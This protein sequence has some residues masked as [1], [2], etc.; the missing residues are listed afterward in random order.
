MTVNP[1]APPRSVLFLVHA[2]PFTPDPR[3]TESHVLDLVGALALPRAVVAYP[4]GTMLEAAEIRDGRVSE[5]A[6]YS[7]PLRRPAERFCV[8]HGEIEGIVRDW[9][10]LFQIA[11]VHIHH[12]MRWP[13]SLG[14]VFASAGVPYI[15]TAHDYYAACLNWNL[16]DY[17]RLAPCDRC[18]GT[19]GEDS[20]LPAFFRQLGDPA[21]ADIGALRRR[22]RAAFQETLSK[23]RAIVWPSQS[24]RE[25]GGRLLPETGVPSQVIEHGCDGAVTVARIPPGERLRAAVMGES[26]FPHKGADRYLDLVHRSRELPIDWHFFGRTRLFGFEEKLREAG[27]EGAVACHGRYSRADILNRLA[28]A[29]IDLSV[30]L[31][32]SPETF[33]FTLSESLLAGV[34][35]LVSAGS[36]ALCERVSR[37]GTGVVVAGVDEA[38][39]ILAGFCDDRAKLTALTERAREFRHRTTRENAEEYRAL[40][41]EC[42]FFRTDRPIAAP[43]H[44]RLR[45]LAERR[46]TGARALLPSEMAG[47]APPS[48]QK[49]RWHARLSR[50]KTLIP[51]SLRPRVRDFL[52]RREHAALRRIDLSRLAGQGEL[53]DLRL[54]RRGLRGADF[55]AMTGGAQF[56]FAIEPLPSRSVRAIRFRLRRPTGGF[57]F[58]RLF[59]T[60]A[61]DEAFSEEKSVQI[62]LDAAAGERREYLVRLDSP[63]LAEKWIAGDQI[64][65]LRFDPINSPGPFELGPLEF[66]S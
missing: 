37:D 14:R 21:P 43:P 47:A 25:I 28:G 48:F 13:I 54:L 4:R 44:E 52:M 5:P 7:F 49:R 34:P 3:G 32:C 45:E 30:S 60:H 56:Q 42:E 35:A 33:G 63:G 2:S 17:S 64:T 53:G 36:G 6:F 50:L 24:A 61:P 39:E 41:A 10:G 38:L 11:A 8:E 40:Y 59:W 51:S 58:S 57:A 46:Q 23:A 16:L 18:Q 31:P 62:V 66:C 65:R 9:I 26:A 15:Y 55:E 22:H 12:L 29:G 27:R 19:D 1:P 20:C